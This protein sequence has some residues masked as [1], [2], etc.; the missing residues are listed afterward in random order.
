MRIVSD[1][2]YHDGATEAT[3]AQLREN[4]HARV[5]QRCKARGYTGAVNVQDTEP[6]LK[7]GTPSVWARQAYVDISD[8]QS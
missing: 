5:I 3:I 8:P 1:Y 2:E 7:A 6:R 4:A